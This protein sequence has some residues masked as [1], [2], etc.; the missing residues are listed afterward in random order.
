M[1][2]F[3]HGEHV[4]AREKELTKAYHSFQKKHSKKN[5]NRLET[6]KRKD[7]FRHNSRYFSPVYRSKNEECVRKTFLVNERTKPSNFSKLFNIVVTTKSTIVISNEFYIT[8]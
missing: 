2:D 6:H 1:W 5:K 8:I 4:E 7:I 3:L